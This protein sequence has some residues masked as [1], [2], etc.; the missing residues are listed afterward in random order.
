MLPFWIA[1]KPW[2]GPAAKMDTQT[3]GAE[4]GFSD[5]EA[6][7]WRLGTERGRWGKEREE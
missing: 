4:T 5:T 7:L 2:P 6:R 1:W 3:P